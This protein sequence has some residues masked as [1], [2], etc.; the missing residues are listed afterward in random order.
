C[1]GSG[2]VSAR[3]SAKA[4]DYLRAVERSGL[5]GRGGVGA[6]LFYVEL[7]R[8]AGRRR[9]AGDHE[10]C[11]R[12]GGAAGEP[13]HLAGAAALA[14]FPYWG[15]GDPGF[16]VGTSPLGRSALRT[17]GRWSHAWFRAERINASVIG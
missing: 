11:A 9:D 8:Y 17:N 12:A 15:N 5:A 6:G 1:R 2:V 4:A 14:E 13:R 16:A 10:Q 3:Q 7:R